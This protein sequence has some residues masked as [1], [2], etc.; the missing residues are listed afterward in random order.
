MEYS[1]GQVGVVIAACPQNGYAPERPRSGVLRPLPRPAPRR[2]NAVTAHEAFT[3]RENRPLPRHAL[4]RTQ[5][6]THD[7]VRRVRTA[8]RR[9]IDDALVATIFFFLC[10]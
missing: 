10:H 3:A 5:H 6:D 8:R 7:V 2:K 1:S 4:A 9:R